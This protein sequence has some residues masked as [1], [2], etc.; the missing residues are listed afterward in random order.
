MTQ[1]LIFSQLYHNIDLT[2]LLLN[3]CYFL[4]CIGS[5]NC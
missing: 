3:R 5:E 1:A 4:Y 2:L